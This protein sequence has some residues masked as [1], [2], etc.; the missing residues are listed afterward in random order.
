M[1]ELRNSMEATDRKVVLAK[2]NGLIIHVPSGIRPDS[3]IMRID[4][5]QFN[6]TGFYLTLCIANGM[7]YHKF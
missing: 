6:Q 5:V 7:L 4:L 2:P 3:C 1:L